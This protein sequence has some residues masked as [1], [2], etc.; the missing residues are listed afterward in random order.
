MATPHARHPNR[1]SSIDLA[2]RPAL[3][4]EFLTALRDRRIKFVEDMAAQWLVSMA[5]LKQ[6]KGMKTIKRDTLRTRWVES[7]NMGMN[8]EE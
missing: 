3:I 4:A 7:Y 6:A 8:G 1:S 5:G 2:D